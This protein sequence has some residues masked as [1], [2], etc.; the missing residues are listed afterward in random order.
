[1]GVPELE[2]HCGSWIVLK[3]GKPI[4]ETFDRRTAERAAGSP[5]L[6]VLTAAQWLA[7]LNCTIRE[8]V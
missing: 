2:P 4:Y 8:T 7:R 3:E 6:E 1:M 5:D